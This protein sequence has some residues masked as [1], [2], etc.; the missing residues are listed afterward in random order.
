MLT[1]PVVFGKGN[2]E[3]RKGDARFDIEL[4]D[5]AIVDQAEAAVR[6]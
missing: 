3:V 5:L 2:K 1:I 6:H 4:L